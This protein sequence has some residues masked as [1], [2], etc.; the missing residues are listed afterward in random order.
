MNG[1]VLASFLS[2]EGTALL[3]GICSAPL[4]YNIHDMALAMALIFLEKEG[5][6][7]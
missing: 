4:V 1:N 5:I 6:L 2:N 7:T 3:S